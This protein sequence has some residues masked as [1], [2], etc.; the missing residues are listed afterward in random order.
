VPELAVTPGLY[1]A[2]S[3]INGSTALVVLDED[4]VTRRRFAVAHAALHRVRWRV[5]GATRQSVEV[6]LRH[7]EDMGED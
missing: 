3:L 1:E 4:A 2:R 6:A 5:G 7:V